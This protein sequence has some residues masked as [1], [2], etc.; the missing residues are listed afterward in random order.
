MIDLTK[1]EL[2]DLSSVPGDNRN[3]LVG[4]T[5]IS[6]ELYKLNT[7]LPPF[8]PNAVLMQVFYKN[9]LFFNVTCYDL[10]DASKTYN[11]FVDVAQ[12][13]SVLSFEELPLMINHEDAFFRSLVKK[14]LER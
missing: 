6:Y 14:R 3:I 8:A 1:Y 12:A 10:D 2:I 13:V 11:R 5:R 4:D 9:D 7:G